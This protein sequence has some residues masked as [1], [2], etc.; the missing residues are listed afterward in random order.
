MPIRS[1][2]ELGMTMGDAHTLA[3]PAGHD[4]KLLHRMTSGS[5]RDFFLLSELKQNV[6]LITVS[7]A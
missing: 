1:L 3:S 7:T 4:Q 6:K 2:R 5:D